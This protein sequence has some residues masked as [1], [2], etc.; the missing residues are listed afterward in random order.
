MMAVTSAAAAGRGGGGGGGMYAVG[1]EGKRIPWGVSA[2]SKPG[3]PIYRLFARNK[4]EI[5]TEILRIHT[6]C[7]PDPFPLCKNISNL[8]LTTCDKTTE[9]RDRTGGCSYEQSSCAVVY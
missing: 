2:S 1:W 5:I 8:F 6:G 7:S 3:V 4:H 9:S